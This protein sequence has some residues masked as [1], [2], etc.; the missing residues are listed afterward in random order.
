MPYEE[1]GGK[2][3]YTAI[4]SRILLDIIE[5]P[6][7]YRGDHGRL[8]LEAERWLAS[9]DFVLTCDLAGLEVEWVRRKIKEAE[10]SKL[11]KSLPGAC[12]TRGWR[13]KGLTDEPL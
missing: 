4:L 12:S 11:G 5:A 9:K 8:R 1:R 6:T 7:G 10:I 2:A 13:T 3:M